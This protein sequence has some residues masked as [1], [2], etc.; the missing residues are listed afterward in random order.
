[1]KETM[2]PA[3]AAALKSHQFTSIHHERVHR[4]LNF[5]GTR[6][7]W[8]VRKMTILHRFRMVGL[9]GLLIAMIFMITSSIDQASLQK[10][11][12]PFPSLAVTT[13]TPASFTIMTF[14]IHHAEG[15]DGKVNLNRI[16]ELLKNEH[17]DV[18]ALQEVDRYR[19]RSGYV[20]Q[21]RELAQ[22]LGM[23][24]CFSPSLTYTVGQYGNAI[25][26]RYPIIDSNWLLLPGEKERRSLLSATLRIGSDDIQIEATHLGLSTADR[27]AQI[28]QISKTLSSIHRPLVLA[29]DFNM[30]ADPRKLESLLNHV[31]PIPLQK[32]F[33][34]TI[35]GGKE[36]DHL[37]T[38]MVNL[39]PAWSLPTTLSDHFPVVARILLGPAVRV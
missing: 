23:H 27:T 38:D 20:D 6:N 7:G 12:V 17:A 37:F 5:V 24:M 8:G 32:G 13:T 10:D 29:G 15:L 28:A 18:I 11:P 39:Q 1:M 31:S 3:F 25:L 35:A 14:N 16:A 4:M 21:A 22:L 36:I 30:E 34:P 9:L 2:N 33:T 26:S 19:L